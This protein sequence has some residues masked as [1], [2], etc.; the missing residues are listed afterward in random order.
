M[1]NNPLRILMIVSFLIAFLVLGA[2]VILSY[3]WEQANA[4]PGFRRLHP[5]PEGYRWDGSAF[6]AEAAAL[7]LQP[8]EPG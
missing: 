7:P 8:G 6:L 1:K 5:E 4:D 3:L 2:G